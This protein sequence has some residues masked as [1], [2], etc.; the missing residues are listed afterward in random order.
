MKLLM[1]NGYKLLTG[2]SGAGMLE[3]G[4]LSYSKLTHSSTLPFCGNTEAFTDTVA[5]NTAVSSA[6]G[7]VLSGP[8]SVLPGVDMPL[9]YIAFASYAAVLYLSYYMDQNSET[10]DAKSKSSVGHFILGLTTCMGSFSLY[11]M[12]VLTA[13]LQTNCLYCYTSAAISLAMAYITYTNN[14]VRNKTTRAVISLS[15]VGVTS[16]FSALLFYASGSQPAEASTAVAAQILAASE[17]VQ[18][19]AAKKES[20]G[21]PAITSKSSPRALALAEKLEKAGAKMYGAYWCSHCY[22]QKQ[23]FGRE[24]FY[25]HIQYLEC[26][27]EGDDSKY[28]MCR[29]RKVPGYPTWEINGELYPGEKTLT[30]LEALLPK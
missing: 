23:E 3:T 19:G 18:T 4:F 27:K 11:L 8:Y 28:P 17:Q 13:V 12:F 26:D 30:E 2:L 6:C 7:D 14:I 15:S 25:Q 16:M 5:A 10:I 24:A 9:V 1:N 21:S 22:N 29:A 20:K